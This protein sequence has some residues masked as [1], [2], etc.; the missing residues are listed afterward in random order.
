MDGVPVYLAS[1]SRKHP[2]L[3]HYLVTE[4]WTPLQLQDGVRQLRQLLGP[5]GDQSRERVFRMNLTLCV[6]RA[7]RDDE[8]AKLP[9]WFWDEGAA[10]LAGG[11][12]EIL[13]ET[14]PGRPS[15]RPCT[16]PTKQ[17]LDL[18]GKSNP[19]IWLPVDCGW[20]ESCLGR[21]AA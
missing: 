10:G 15:T 13:S 2:V 12:V 6:H 17:P 7:M 16:N 21:K 1:M 8:V 18:G 20:C 9:A 19:K 5:A 11:P 3:G 4:E 14:V